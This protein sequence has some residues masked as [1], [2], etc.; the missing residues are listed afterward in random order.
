MRNSILRGHEAWNKPGVPTASDIR[1]L[2]RHVRAQGKETT[3]VT[4]TRKRADEINHLVAE[5]MLGKRRTLVHL[6]GDYDGNPDNFDNRG[7]LRTV[8]RP[9]P[10]VIHIKKDMRPR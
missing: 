8:R 2:L 6:C 9:V 4:C 10:T 3:I 1:K 7:K 5:V